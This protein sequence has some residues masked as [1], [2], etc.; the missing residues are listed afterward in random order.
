[1]KKKTWNVLF[2]AKMYPLDWQLGWEF[3]CQTKGV[4]FRALE[5]S[6]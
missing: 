6:D 1:M 5:K 2:W 4:L 3:G